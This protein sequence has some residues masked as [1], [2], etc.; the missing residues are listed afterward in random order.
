MAENLT[1]KDIV[2][3]SIGYDLTPQVTLPTLIQQVHTA[4]AEILKHSHGSDVYILGHSAGSHLVSSILHSKQFEGGLKDVRGIFLIS[5]LY[6]L[7][8]I[9][10]CWPNYNVKMDMK[11][12]TDS[13]PL[14]NDFVCF[15]SD[16]KKRIQIV[17]NYGENDTASFKSQSKLY[18]TVSFE[19]DNFLL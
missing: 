14:L 16:E 4:F 19:V 11:V 10:E 3:C 7:R 6:D 17:A 9:L 13:S 1:A 12:A 15:S 5:G 18:A 2:V 8:P